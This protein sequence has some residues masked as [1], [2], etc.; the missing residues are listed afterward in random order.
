MPLTM[1]EYEHL[2]EGIEQVQGL[3]GLAKAQLE[4]EETSPQPG[5]ALSVLLTALDRAYDDAIADADG[6]VEVPL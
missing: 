5:N 4:V 2:R 3:T 1:E 6:V